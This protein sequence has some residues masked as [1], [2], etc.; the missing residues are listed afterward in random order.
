MKMSDP[1]TGVPQFYIPATAS[2]LERR[3]RTLK[4]GDTFAMFDHYGDLAGGIA[5]PQGLYHQDTR[6]LSMLRIEIEGRR[7]LLLSSTVENNNA[8]LTVDLTNPDIYLGDELQLRRDSIHLLRSKFLWASA[9]YEAIVVHNYLQEPRTITVSLQYE[10]DFRDLFEVRGLA[11]PRRGVLKRFTPEMHRVVLRYTGIDERVRDT[12]LVFDPAP[13]RLSE[14]RAEWRVELAAGARKALFVTAVC[15]TAGQSDCRFVSNLRRAHRARLRASRRQAT[16]RTSNHIFNELLCRSMADL[17][18]LTADTQHGLYPYAGIPWFSTVFGRDGIITAI[19]MLAFD[20]SL[21]RGVLNFLAATQARELDATRDAEPGKILHE[22]RQGEMAALGEIP[23]GMY[24]GSVDSTPLFVLLAGLYWERSGDLETIRELW[25]N[26]CAALEWIDR[27][28]DCDGDGFVEYLRKSQNGLANQGWK[29]SEDSVFHANGALAHG[30]ITL[31]EVQAYVYAAKVHAARMAAKLNDCARAQQLKQDA[32]TLRLQ[33]EQCFWMEDQG[34]YILALD[35]EKQPCRVVSSNPGHAL[36][37]GIASP[38]HALRVAQLLT[39]K[40]LF[41]G[42]GIRTIST[43]E[44]RYN[45]MSY[46]NGSIWPHDNALAALGLAR[47]GHMSEAVNVLTA[48]FDASKHM[49]LRRL[50]ELYCGIRR[51][52]G[53]G[54]TFY[55]VACSPQA[56][57]SAAPFALLTAVLGLQLDASTETVRFVYPRLPD[58]LNEVELRNLRLGS[59]ALDILL[60]RRG[61][62]VA[63]NVVGK[64]GPARVEVVI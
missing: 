53:R 37:C 28:G 29:D 56:W 23:F 2:L 54:P 10:A 51:K 4:H 30:A 35:G 19:E 40:Q 42:W 13:D 31:C 43:V 47:Y 7:P 24:Y 58:F 12:E 21:A 38:Q 20:P 44:S 27:Y 55:P 57:A 5:N 50:P 39:A 9:C 17:V 25:P 36:F 46:H 52:A 11:R 1:E 41:S 63:V 33:F 8:L 45:P 32:A 3:P 34:F 64:I 16:V 49:E 48:I 18:M 15:G 62:T 60:H 14:Q 59:S 61:S 6:Y 26:I 22:V